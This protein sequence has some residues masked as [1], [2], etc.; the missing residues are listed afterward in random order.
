MNSG[1]SKTFIFLLTILTFPKTHAQGINPIEIINKAIETRKNIYS[2]LN[3]FKFEAYSRTTSYNDKNEVTRLREY[4][5]NGQ[6][7]RPDKYFEE[8]TAHRAYG[9]SGVY[10]PLGAVF[11]FAEDR[12]D[13]GSVS[14]LL[15][16]AAGA[17]KIYNY[18]YGSQIIIEDI[19]VHE[20]IIN[21]KSDE[22]PAVKGKI[23]ISETDFE[24]VKIFLEFNKASLPTFIDAANIN[25][26]KARFYQKY[27][28][29]FEQEIQINYSI[30]GIVKGHGQKLTR[31]LNYELNTRIDKKIFISEKTGFK[32]GFSKK[33]SLFWVENNPVSLN[34][35]EKAAVVKL[36]K[37][38]IFPGGLTISTD[39]SLSENLNFMLKNP[40]TLYK[41]AAEEVV[42]DLKKG[43]SSTSINDF[44]HFNRVEGPYLGIGLK[45]SDASLK[46]F[47]WF[48][49][50]GY[51]FSD[52]K[53]KYS[54]GLR[55]WF[56]FYP[57]ISAG[58]EYFNKMETL[59]STGNI[60]KFFNTMTSLIGKF[61]YSDYYL[62][63]GFKLDLS[64]NPG[65]NLNLK[66]I[67]KN[68][69]ESTVE[70]NTN[71][72]LLNG[73]KYR[74]NP[75]AVEGNLKSLGLNLIFNKA[76]FLFTEVTTFGLDY[77]YSN[78]NLLKSDFNYSTIR[79]YCH[80]TINLFNSNDLNTYLEYSKG[81]GDVPYHKYFPIN[82]KAPIANQGY[83]KGTEYREF[84][85]KDIFVGNFEYNFKG[86]I[87]RKL[88]LPNRIRI[89][90][91]LIPFFSFGKTTIPETEKA[92]VKLFTG[93][94]DTKGVYKEYGFGI[95]HKS[96]IFRLNFLW[97][98]DSLE[99]NTFKFGIFLFTN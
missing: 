49:K 48:G 36:R 97:R 4:F 39:R 84:T 37:G 64:M 22:I 88:P 33:D 59:N 55:K 42:G 68:Q 89:R 70:T 86:S 16:F 74:I 66:F 15:P 2:D 51:G 58:I 57:D 30:I 7:Q 9:N 71:I 93:R 73:Y 76:N 34:K 54:I 40:K 94:Y 63:K 25:I 79:L 13:L 52:K 82:G 96:K 8:I 5:F 69:K 65:N 29:P 11:D 81:S 19:L 77:E 17:E 46:S 47:K 80:N 28:L 27:W 62:A 12:I 90:Y 67:Y 45:T 31:Y 87:I 85:G 53:I 99:K 20:L 43:I 6:W 72:G 24:I 56:S 78:K 26:R 32:E 38:R 23:W 44:F 61:D 92:Q 95:G 35:E 10:F 98:N 60:S 91:E 3:N 83:L 18:K 21:P 50:F 75:Q 1:I 41:T 14:V